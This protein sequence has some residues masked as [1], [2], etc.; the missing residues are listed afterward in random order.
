MAA[1]AE[2]GLVGEVLYDAKAVAERTG[3]LGKSLAEELAQDRPVVVG[4]LTGAAPFTTDL[5]RAMAPC[6]VGTEL[7]FVRAS[8]YHGG[9][10][11]SGEVK[12]TVSS[13]LSLRGRTVVVVEDIIDT[14]LTMR[15]LVDH[16][17]EKEG[18]SKLIVVTLL[19]KGERRTADLSDVDIRVG[20]EIPDKFVV[21]YGLDFDGRFRTLPYVGVLHPRAYT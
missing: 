13:S 9:T 2:E 12:L 5:V 20:F 14:G 19:N 16:L 15:S 8:S 11:S 17:R 7:E 1:E 3:A 18:V 21:G 6:P 4:V 10:E